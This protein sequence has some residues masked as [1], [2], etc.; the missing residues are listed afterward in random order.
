MNEWD[1]LHY[2]AKVF[3]L[4]LEKLRNITLTRLCSA[5]VTK[6]ILYNEQKCILGQ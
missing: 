2:I 4:G 6:L 3:H 5:V 1:F